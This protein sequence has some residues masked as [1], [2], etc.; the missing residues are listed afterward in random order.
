MG[1]LV[2]IGNDAEGT[3]LASIEG[4]AFGIDAAGNLVLNTE[5]T[6]TK[7]PSRGGVP[8]ILGTGI[9]FN[10]G[11][12]NGVGA[13]ANIANVTMQVQDCYGNAIAGVFEFDLYLSDAA[14]GVGLTATTA[15]GGIAAATSG[16]TVLGALTTSKAVRVTT[17]AAGQFVLA[18]TDTAKT[19]FFPVAGLIPGLPV[20]IG[21]QLTTASY[22]T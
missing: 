22:H 7:A 13:S 1:S 2:S 4:R 3:V 19:A 20:Q 6:Q 17:N 5:L 16:G 15:S 10:V 11:I 21:A 12:T 18:I 14:T 9:P 8:A